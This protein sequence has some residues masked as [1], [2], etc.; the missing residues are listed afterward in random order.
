[1]KSGRT[2]SNTIALIVRI[3]CL[4]YV[5]ALA[6]ID[7]GAGERYVSS[8][9]LAQ[10]SW[11][12]VSVAETGIHFISK[13][14]L[15][16]WGFPDVD[17]V[18][19]FGYGGKRLDDYLDPTVYIDDLPRVQ[20]LRF[21]EGIYFFAT[22]PQEIKTDV[23][24][25][26]FYISNPFS[27]Y[28]YYFLSDTY[29]EEEE[30]IIKTT[31]YD[32]VDNGASASFFTCVLQHEIDRY[33]PGE[34]G[35]YMVGEDLK[36]TPSRTFGFDLTDMVDNGDIS[37][38][39]SVMTNLSSGASWSLE[40]STGESNTVAVPTTPTDDNIHGNTT[41]TWITVK[42]SHGGTLNA[43]VSLDAI[44]NQ[45]RNAFLD[46]IAVNYTRKIRLP[47]NGRPTLIF[48]TFSQRVALENAKE[49][50]VVW[51]V[52]DP[53]DILQLN[54]SDPAA[55]NTVNFSTPLQGERRYVAF[56]TGQGNSF[57]SPLL[58]GKVANQNLHSIDDVDMVIFT[59]TQGETAAEKLAVHRSTANGLNVKVINQ[60]Q[61]FNEFSSGV[62]D[63]NAF[64]K[65]MKLLW[66]RASTSG[67]RR[68]RYV[69]L[70]GRGSFDNRRI[71]AATA[72]LPYE[73]MPMWQTD[74]GIDDNYS[75]PTD[76]IIAI[77]DDYSGRNMATD[78]LNVSVGRL[79]VTTKEQA[80][81]MVD[82]II[83]YDIDSPLG[84]WRNKAVFIADD[85][86]RG[87][88]MEQTEAMI[89]NIEGSEQNR[90][91]TEKIYLDAYE[92][93][94]GIA[95]DARKEFYRLLDEGAVW[96][97]YVGHANTSALS[98]EGILR[99]ADMD[100]LY[101]RTLPFIY[102]ATCDFMR[103]DASDLSGA[104]M[105]AATR[106][107]GVIGAISATRPVYIARNGELTAAMGSLLNRRNESGENLTTGELLMKAKNYLGHDDNK[108]RYALLGDPAMKLKMPENKVVI[109]S[110]DGKP[111]D[112]VNDDI[113]VKGNQR[114][115]ITGHI[116]N[117]ATGNVETD[118]YG[119][120]SLHIFDAEESVTTHAHGNNGVN[121]SFQKHGT[122]LFAGNDSIKGGYFSATVILPPEIADNYANARLVVYAADEDMDKDAS[123]V[124]N[125][126]YVYGMD[127]SAVNDTIPPV[128]EEMYL[129]HPSF[130][131]G[132]VVNASPVLMAR[133]SDNYAINMSLAGIGHWMSLSLDNGTS[134]FAD[135]SNYYEAET[136]N[137]GFLS[138]PLENLE[139]GA[140]TLTLR[141]WDAAGNSAECSINFY[142]DTYAPIHV[143][144]IYADNSPATASANFYLVHDRPD[145]NLK[146][147]LMI[148]DI[149]GRAVW[150]N[151]SVGKADRYTTA[152]ISWNLTD[153]SGHRVARGI[154]LY[155]AVVKEAGNDNVTGQAV[156]TPT[157]KLA[158]TSR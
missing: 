89:S 65:L 97:N 80:L 154:Y 152:P 99:Y 122:R 61:V 142:V 90:L 47:D 78:T 70:M 57:P 72:N 155:R 74:E 133:I 140:H 102:A 112:M 111:T 44:S 3:M 106:G 8:S 34:T 125:N 124:E 33:S 4:W 138:Y 38:G 66:D 21:P 144:D 41:T 69:L 29:T 114:F 39:A 26:S 120:V 116:E 109:D 132:K 60:Q 94:N 27:N 85:D 98:G 35:H 127:E 83:A 53:L 146:V 31:G 123:I 104:E 25:H 46:W 9:K 55:E 45:V 149:M 20:C 42:G 13:R 64:R 32:S 23:R 93:V 145:A 52:T 117:T 105:L 5:M 14:Q 49:N 86:D 18:G 108:L 1:M 136:V 100:E 121:F 28:G 51:D 153:N 134:T 81:L 135:V 96:V 62:P 88:H 113:V 141:V 2:S 148:Y 17:K 10:G 7:C 157:K 6:A 131:D 19:V 126:F 58:V 59:T 68:P 143:Y 150:S 48:T 75:Y 82:K 128:I 40:I 110:I 43:T 103:W 12:K 158:V 79:P 107:G 73:L 50:T 118:F 67:S 130:I 24:G 77:L 147:E 87:I 15:A 119:K 37:V 139:D 11:I 92:Y 36:Y 151:T 156:V 95:E 129:N 54:I 115:V 84:N 63:V 91:L 71:T 16:S 76:D 101:L 137:N 22:G 30:P 56:N